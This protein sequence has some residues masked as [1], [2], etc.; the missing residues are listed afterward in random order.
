M[1]TEMDLLKAHCQP[2]KLIYCIMQRGHAV[3]VVQALYQQ[4]HILGIDY[5]S[6]R[7]Q[8]SSMGKHEWH[9]IDILIV[10][11]APEFAD[12]VFYEMYT[13]ARVHETEGAMIYQ[14]NLEVSTNYELPELTELVEEIE[15]SSAP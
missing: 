8:E 11:V 7:N 10:V 9:E 12:E 14:A 15:K 3:S 1:T 13:L 6:G 2:A 5:T 4:H